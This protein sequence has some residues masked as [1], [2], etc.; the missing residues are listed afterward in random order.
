[1]AS[2]ILLFFGEVVFL[3]GALFGA[4]L[5]VVFCGAGVFDEPREGVGFF[6]VGSFLFLGGAE[7]FLN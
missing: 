7:I 5:A 4:L 1:M 3:K 6:W 2:A